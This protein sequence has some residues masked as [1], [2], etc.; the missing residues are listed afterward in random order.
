MWHVNCNEEMKGNATCKN[1]C[2]LSHLL[3]DLGVTHGVH[4]WLDGKCVVDFLLV[5]IERLSLAVTASALLSEICRNRLFLKGWVTLS[6]N[7]RYMGMPSAI[8][9]WTVRYRNDVATTL[10]LEVFTQRNFAADCFWQKLNFT[11]KNSKIAFCAT[12]W[13]T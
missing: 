11:G 6:A 4:L 12:L 7:F 9:L 8:H 5:I 1:S 10:L 2:F 3:G 13:R